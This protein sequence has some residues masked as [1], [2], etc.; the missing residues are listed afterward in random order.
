VPLGAA[1]ARTHLLRGALAGAAAGLVT[2]VYN[3]L[4]TER[5]LDRAVAL[6]H[7][8]GGPVSRETQKYLGGPAG[9]V[10]FGISMGLLFALAYRFV[11]GTATPWRRALGLALGMY[12]VIALIPQLRYPANPPGVGEA[13][14][15]QARTSAYL[16]TYALGL[17]VVPG[18]YAALRALRQRGVSEPVR[19]VAVV[20][21]A[22]AA[23]ALVYALLPDSNDPD[24]LPAGLVWAFRIRALGG[25]T[26]FFAALGVLFGLLTERAERA[27]AAA[28]VAEPELALR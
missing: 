6:E 19:Q 2:A 4:L 8:H 18:A 3:L 23:V 17:V 16:L 13:D 26:L 9:Q 14:T 22:V 27:A 1:P 24:T 25:L 20:V 12:L 5:V 7:D 28:P 10:L 15:I 21:G 11:P